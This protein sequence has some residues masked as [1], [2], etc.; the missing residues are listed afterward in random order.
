[1]VSNAIKKGT[2]GVWEALLPMPLPGFHDYMVTTDSP[3]EKLAAI[4]SVHITWGTFLWPYLRI[5]LLILVI[6][7]VIKAIRQRM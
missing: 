5:L 6:I 1:L 3:G 7:V 2:D 4:Q